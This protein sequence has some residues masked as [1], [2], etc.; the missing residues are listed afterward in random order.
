MMMVAVIFLDLFSAETRGLGVTGC[1]KPPPKPCSPPLLLYSHVHNQT[2]D[3]SASEA[4]SPQSPLGTVVHMSTGAHHCAEGAGRLFGPAFAAAPL[5]F[6]VP[7]PLVPKAFPG[8]GWGRWFL[9]AVPLLQQG[10][11]LSATYRIVLVFGTGAALFGHA[12]N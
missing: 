7:L 5:P 8:R 3:L 4:W 1:P 10:S 9:H 2:L 12:L 6:Q 11:S